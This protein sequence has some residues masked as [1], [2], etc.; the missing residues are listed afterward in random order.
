[1]IGEDEETGGKWN[2]EVCQDNVKVT[3]FCPIRK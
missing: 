3:P 1:M 2:G